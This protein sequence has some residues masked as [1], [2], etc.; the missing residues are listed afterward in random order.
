M[1]TNYIFLF[2][3]LS[4][5]IFC[6][7][8]QSAQAQENNQSNQT[9]VT[10]DIRYGHSD[11]KTDEILN[12]ITGKELMSEKI[13]I[14]LE[15]K[16]LYKILI[17]PNIFFNGR[18]LA[19][20][21]QGSGEIPK[22][23]D[24]LDDLLEK[25][26]D[27]T[28]KKYRYSDQYLDD[29]TNVFYCYYFYNNDEVTDKTKLLLDHFISR[30]SSQQETIISLQPKDL[31]KFVVHQCIN[32]D[33]LELSFNRIFSFPAYKAVWAMHRFHGNPR[34]DFS[35]DFSFEM[36]YG[37]RAY[38]NYKENIIYLG[39][40]WIG[41]IEM[42]YQ[43]WLS[44]L[45]HAE[46]W[47]YHGTTLMNTREDNE[48]EFIDSIRAIRGKFYCYKASTQMTKDELLYS[49]QDSI[50]GYPSIE[51]EA[52]EI[53]EPLLREEFQVLITNY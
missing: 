45:S 25:N 51:F 7:L 38:Y 1:K 13:K 15:V 23:K 53:I 20:S 31:K 40:F 3:I 14:E 11:A 24:R 44:E 50:R 6:P 17:S 52:H 16:M 28:Y 30:D 5:L 9:T 29:V 37:S 4:V 42:Y 39:I 41:G 12:F 43:D 21:F 34:L 10:S 47:H 19:D 27:D 18:S 49:K 48:V 22:I 46:Q 36:G 8:T 35:N 32:F 2:V 33:N 26:S